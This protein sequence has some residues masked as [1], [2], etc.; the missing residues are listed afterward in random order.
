MSRRRQ[1]NAPAEGAGELIENDILVV[2]AGIA[3]I[4]T[5]YRLKTKMPHLSFTVLESREEI[6]G[7]WDIF[8]YPGVRSDSDMYTFGFPW[9]PWRGRVLGDGDEIMSYLH[10]CVSTYGLKDYLNFGHKVVDAD[11]SS[12]TQ[13]WTINVDHKGQPKT[14]VAKWLVLGTGLF[15]AEKP[16]P[17]VIPGIENFQGKTIHPHFWPADYDY[18]GKKI[19]IIGSGATTITLLPALVEGGAKKVTMLQRSPSHIANVPVPDNKPGM[20]GRLIPFA[21]LAWLRRMTWFGAMWMIH[22]MCAKFPDM[23]S[24]NLAGEARKSLPEKVPIEPHF[25]PAYNPWEQRLCL[26]KDGDF[27]KA[28]HNDKADVVTSTIKTVTASGIELND[29]TTLDADVIVTATGSIIRFG[30]GIPISVDSEPVVWHKKLLWNGCMVQDV[31][32]MFFMWGYTNVSWT[33]GV[34]Q[35]ATIMYRLFNYMKGKGTRVAVP[36]LPERSQP[37]THT[38]WDLS[39]TYRLAMEPYLPKYGSEGNWRPRRYF[40]SDMIHA[41]WGSVTDGLKFLS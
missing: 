28:F 25:K 7:T 23:V 31:P 24:K 33:L 38:M 13:R 15:D 10:E 21:S 35:T 1:T 30:G 17:T 29:G 14:Y 36:Q 8:R 27:F 4:N 34:D 3:G 11:W 16:F 12:E 18:T 5:A 22:F 41:S 37:K 40:I 26:T 39:A 19:I 6:G 2:G 32:N 9:H 20:L